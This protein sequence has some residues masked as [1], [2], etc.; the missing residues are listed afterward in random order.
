[1]KANLKYVLNPF[2]I[3]SELIK[4]HRTER[5]IGHLID[6]GIW[7]AAGNIPSNT[8]ES[9]S[10]QLTTGVIK[11]LDERSRWYLQL[12]L[13]KP[14]MIIFVEKSNDKKTREKI[15]QGKKGYVISLLINFLPLGFFF[16]YQRFFDVLVDSNT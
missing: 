6:L 4:L 1:M 12:E 16:L 2:S 9:A 8:S 3:N 5:V 11:H 14:T 7:L 10:M 15:K 13:I